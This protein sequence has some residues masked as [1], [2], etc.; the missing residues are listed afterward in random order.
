M[1]AIHWRLIDKMAVGLV[2]TLLCMLV[3]SQPVR[4]QSLGDVARKERQKQQSKDARPAKKV[5][6]DDDMPEHPASEPSAT[7]SK[8]Q[9]KDFSSA[10]SAEGGKK[11]A[12]RWKAEIQ[13]QKNVVA[14]LQRS[15]DR[16]NSSIHFVEANRYVDGAE[17][18]QTQMQKQQRAQ[19]MQV[20]LDE[21]KQKL[22]DMQEAA[23]RAG[24]GN[25]V[26]DP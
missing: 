16:L 12:E 19:Q 20:Q 10:L 17:Y 15:L 18:N 2:A 8:D 26:Y 14:S 25:A 11:S 22:E 7:S 1:S 9:K 24:F 23:R 5:I 4:G 3:Q 6:T 21:Q 13:A